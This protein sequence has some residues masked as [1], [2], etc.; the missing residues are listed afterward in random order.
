[1]R[2]CWVFAGCLW[3]FCVCASVYVFVWV[4]ASLCVMWLGGDGRK[5]KWW[6]FEQ[7]RTVCCLLG[8]Y[9]FFH[10]HSINSCQVLFFIYV[11]H[12]VSLCR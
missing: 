6:G 1:M 4:S 7:S 12:F 2:N 11:L 9:L 3:G 8:G 5:L 10:L